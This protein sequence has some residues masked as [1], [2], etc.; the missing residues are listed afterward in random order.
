MVSVCSHSATLVLTFTCIFYRRPLL[1][2]RIYAN[3]LCSLLEFYFSRMVLEGHHLCMW[4]SLLFLA[5]NGLIFISFSIWELYLIVSMW[6][7]W[8]IWKNQMSHDKIGQWLPRIMQIIRIVSRYQSDSLLL[9]VVKI[10]KYFVKILEHCLSLDCVSNV[11]FR[12]KST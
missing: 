12:C 1:C 8:I 6:E 7:C 10:I 5:I 2:N 11:R 4:V 3:L 9:T